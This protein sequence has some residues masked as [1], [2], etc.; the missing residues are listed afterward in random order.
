MDYPEL[1]KSKRIGLEDL[2]L[3]TN[4][5]LGAT[6]EMRKEHERFVAVREPFLRFNLSLEDRY[7]TGTHIDWRAALAFLGTIVVGILVACWAGGITDQKMQWLADGLGYSA[8]GIFLGGLVWTSWLQRKEPG[9]FFRKKVLPELR[10]ALQALQPS[11]AELG[12][13]LRRLGKYRYRISKIVRAED[14]TEGVT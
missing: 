10:L 4:P 9:R 2:A 3:R 13:C 14:I 8:A 5:L 1:V 12:E 7:A 6:P 11:R